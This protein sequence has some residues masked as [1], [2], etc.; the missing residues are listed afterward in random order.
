M[1]GKRL[2]LQLVVPPL[3]GG[4]LLLRALADEAAALLALHA[5]ADA[6]GLVE[7]E[8]PEDVGPGGVVGEV[9]VELAGDV[10]E[11]VEAGPGDGGEV[12]VLVVQA[13]VVREEVEGAVVRVRLGDGDAVGRVGLRGRHRRVHV[14]LGD[15]VPRERVQAARQE[16]GEDEVQHGPRAQR[17]EHDGVE[18]ELHADVDGRHPREGHAVHGH[19]P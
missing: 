8:A 13:D 11:R 6:D 2:G 4:L 18:G 15:E 19:G 14:V 7:Y 3:L 12:V 16:G 9:G 10:V 5:A 1:S 17:G